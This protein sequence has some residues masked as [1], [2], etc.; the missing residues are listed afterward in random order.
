MKILVVDD[1]PVARKVLN[2]FLTQS[3]YDVDVVEDAEQAL[4]AMQEEDA[5]PIA[6]IDWQMPEMD[7]LELCAALREMDLPLQPYLF[8]LHTKKDKNDIAQAL[9]AGAD[10]YLTKPFNMVETCARL[11][12]A[13]RSIA[14][15]QALLEEI[16]RLRSGPRE[17]PAASA[18]NAD[19]V[20]PLPFEA[21]QASTTVSPFAESK[22]P[23]PPPLF[24]ADENAPPPPFELE[25]LFLDAVV[26]ETLSK[27]GLMLMV[28]RTPFPAAMPDYAAW[29]GLLL[30]KEDLWLDL[31]LEADEASLTKLFTLAKRREDFLQVELA[32]FCAT[33]ILSIG[34]EIKTIL[35]GRGSEVLEP[36]PAC[37]TENHAGRLSNRLPSGATRLH[38]EIAQ[39][40]I[41]LVILPHASPRQSLRVDQVHAHDILASYYPP[42]AAPEHAPFRKGLALEGSILNKIKE[43]AHDTPGNPP[44]AFYRPSPLAVYFNQYRPTGE[45]G[46]AQGNPTSPSSAGR[47]DHP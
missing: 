1:D 21:G 22:A 44:I 38:Y 33:I 26:A 47:A 4:D 34:N 6:I 31:L 36:F 25:S 3:N 14:R 24:V 12:V 10:D 16:E 7:G 29:F 13:E 39:A 2:A 11:R 15:Q 20:A 43:I 28:V 30:T 46:P 8:I 5:P 40:T 18:L 27:S 32:H 23:E 19:P 41:T 37:T 42:A 35:S 9:D 17:K 45:S